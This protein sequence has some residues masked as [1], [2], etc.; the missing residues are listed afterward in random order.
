VVTTQRASLRMD[1]QRE[2]EEIAL[3]TRIVEDHECVVDP[4]RAQNDGRGRPGGRIWRC[5]T[6]ENPTDDCR[7]TGCREAECYLLTGDTLLRPNVECDED[8][9]V[10]DR[11]GEID[12][13]RVAA[14]RT[15]CDD[16][17]RVRTRSDC[18]YHRLRVGGRNGVDTAV[19]VAKAEDP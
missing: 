9:T 10:G 1:G 8:R 2:I 5:P 12:G 17:P 18:R 13:L 3:I 16:R 7:V 19:R 15:P 4:G 6:P 11:V 14:R